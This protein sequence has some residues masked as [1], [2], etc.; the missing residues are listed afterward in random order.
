MQANQTENMD[1]TLNSIETEL[2]NESFD[3]SID[4]NT[5]K[6]KI[7]KSQKNEAKDIIEKDDQN[8]FNKIIFLQNFLIFCFIVVSALFSNF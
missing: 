4:T 6:K 5:Q 3:D 7:E 2:S 8:F 1:S